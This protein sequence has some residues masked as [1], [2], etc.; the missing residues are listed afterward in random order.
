MGN[1]MHRIRVRAWRFR[2]YPSQKIFLS[3]AIRFIRLV[4][5]SSLFF[6]QLFF[7]ISSLF[8]E[9]VRFTLYNTSMIKDACVIIY[10]VSS[11][12]TSTPD[13]VIQRV[14]NECKKSSSGT[15]PT[16]PPSCMFDVYDPEP[17]MSKG[18][19]TI[20]VQSQSSDTPQA[21]IFNLSVVLECLRANGYDCRWATIST[22]LQHE[23]WTTAWYTIDSAIERHDMQI[24]LVNRAAGVHARPASNAVHPGTV[25]GGNTKGKVWFHSPDDVALLISSSPIWVSIWFY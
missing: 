18:L 20:I 9:R 7:P 1:A 13:E 8:Y 6:A 15:T 3:T 22:S 21:G 2:G 14:I 5:Q 11:T 12:D 4:R 17:H 10:K 16:I 25:I 23:R 24:D 19:H